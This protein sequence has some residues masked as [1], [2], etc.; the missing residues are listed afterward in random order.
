M[1]RRNT[2]NHMKEYKMKMKEPS[3]GIQKGNSGIGLNSLPQSLTQQEESLPQEFSIVPNEFKQK[4]SN[5][6]RKPRHSHGHSTIDEIL[7]THKNSPL[8]INKLST[9]HRDLKRFMAVNYK[10][11]NIA[12]SL[13]TAQNF[14]PSDHDTN[15]ML[16]ITPANTF[17]ANQPNMSPIV[18]RTA[19][20]TMHPNRNN[21]KITP[22]HKITPNNQFLYQHQN[23]IQKTTISP[24]RP[25]QSRVF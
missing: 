8:I 9:T 14:N 10:N 22:P 5:S 2:S 16:N 20:G 4:C 21:V 23:Q 11:M 15:L 12:P 19:Q 6:M 25:T 3:S 7:T 18:P 17:T 13:A 1:K 24:Y